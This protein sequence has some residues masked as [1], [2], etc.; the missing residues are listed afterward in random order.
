M[1]RFSFRLETLLELRV[2]REDEVKQE[3]GK[4]NLR[5]ATSRKEL[6]ALADALKELQEEEKQKRLGVKSAVELRYGVAYRFKLKKDILVK[7]RQIDDFQAQALAVRKKLVRAKQERRAI[8]IV[9]ERQFDAWKKKYR[10]REQ[11]FTDD[12]SQQSY[13]RHA[14]EAAVPAA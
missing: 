8:E 12:I 6:V 11:G 9:R 4:I 7:G 10:T 1:K 3:L 5:I 14:R 2:R 13:I